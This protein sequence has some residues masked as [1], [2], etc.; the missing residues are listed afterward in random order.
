MVFPKVVLLFVTDRLKVY[1]LKK[2]ARQFLF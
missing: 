2:A 1:V